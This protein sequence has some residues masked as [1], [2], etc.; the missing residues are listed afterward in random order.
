MRKVSFAEK[1]ITV[2]IRFTS[3]VAL[4]LK[5]LLLDFINHF[6][7]SFCQMKSLKDWLWNNMEFSLF[8]IVEVRLVLEMSQE[9]LS[10]ADKFVEV[11]FWK[12]FLSFYYD[13]VIIVGF[14]CDKNQSSDSKN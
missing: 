7:G 9:F 11:N 6:N 5:E 10:S 1:A 3:Y 4:T 12:S 13:W 2:E 14:G 8:V